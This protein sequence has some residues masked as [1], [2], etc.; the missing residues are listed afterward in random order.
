MERER[1]RR[2]VESG[3]AVLGVELGSTRIKAVLIAP[4]GAPL[5]QGAHRWENHFEDGNWTYP[6]EEVWSGLRAAYA[7]LA[8]DVGARYGA[9]PER[10][11][12]AGVS[13]MMHGYL[14]FDGSGNLLV[15]F[16]TWR[17]TGTRRAAEELTGALGCNIP[18]RWSAAHLYQAILNREPHVE[19]VRFLTTLSGYVHW[20]LTGKKVL[21]IGDAAGMFPVDGALGT[22]DPEKLNVFDKMAGRHG[23]SKPLRTLL[24]EVLRAGEP[25][26]ALTAAGAELLDPTGTLR[27]GVPM[28]PPEG[29]AG[30]GMA[31]T[32]A[33]APRTGNISAGTSVFAMVVLE[34]PLS[35]FYPELD[36]VATPT[37]RAVAMVHCNNGTSDLDAWVRLLRQAGLGRGDENAAYEMFYRAALAGE[38]DCGGVTVCNF[39]SGEPVTGLDAGIPLL[40]RTPDARL[41]LEN[42]ARANLLGA[43]AALKLGMEILTEREGA[44]IDTLT[45]HGGLFQTGGAA[46]RLL[47]G[48]L[49]I[50]VR[51][52]ETAESGGPWGMALLAGYLVRKRDGEPLEDFLRE[53]VF[54]RVRS[55]TARPDPRDADGA[56]AYLRRYRKLLDVERGAVRAFQSAPAD[57]KEEIGDAPEGV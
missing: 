39:L 17:N 37:G 14:A 54:R 25:A 35:G 6:L 12:A 27:P 47:A 51:C 41:T 50:P 34:R 15:P 23:F 44:A 29:D 45:G 24:P 26:G 8:A 19:K 5:A 22:F 48:V 2:I 33:L 53:R 49:G 40:T 32:D 30:T 1:G 31:A 52:M 10:L 46:Q 21:G 57:K 7:D 4:D 9:P 18:Q 42:F 20:R 38:P 3:E 55:R 16:R 13:A 43:M 56:A 11:A 36:T 28:A